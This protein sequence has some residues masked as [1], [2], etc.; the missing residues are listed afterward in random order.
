MKSFF[1]RRVHRLDQ[2]LVAV[3][4]IGR[5]PARA[6]MLRL[7]DRRSGNATGAMAWYLVAG[8]AIIMARLHFGGAG[9]TL[10]VRCG[11]SPGT[12]HQKQIG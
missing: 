2:R 8:L 11:S 5:E 6:V 7:G 12:G 4:Q 10:A 3:A 9:L 1:L